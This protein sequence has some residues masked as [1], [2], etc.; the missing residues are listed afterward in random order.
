MAPFAGASL[1][2]ALQQGQVLLLSLDQTDFGNRMAVLMITLRVWDRSLTL[3]W[4]A[5][6]GA[7]N[8]GF[9]QQQIVLAQVLAWIPVGGQVML[10]AD[11]FYP[12][13]GLFQWLQTQDW[14]YRLRLKNNLVVDPGFGDET[15]T[16]P[17][18]QGVT[19]PY[20]PNVRLSG[21]GEVFTNL[22]ILHESGHAEPW[23]IAMDCA[24][25]RAASWTTVR[26]AL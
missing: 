19:E 9:A 5:E 24:P 15:T 14:Q 26:I 13:A 21:H 1:R 16:G 11:R 17:L 10:L 18:A 22:G 3:A 20:L 23:I 6:A 12:S 7:A 25:T 4:L 2:K 8:I